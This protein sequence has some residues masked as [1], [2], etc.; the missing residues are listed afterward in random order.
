MYIGC[1]GGVYGSANLG[2]TFFELNR[3]Y[4][5]QTFY[6]IANSSALNKV[7]GGAQDNGTIYIPGDGSLPTLQSG[8]PASGG[9]G[10]G[11]E[12]SLVTEGATVAF[13]TSQNNSL[14][15]INVSAAA[16]PSPFYD[17]NITNFTG[18]SDG[19]GLPF[20]TDI[21][22]FE[23]TEDEDSQQTIELVNPYDYDLFDADLTDDTP[24]QLLV[25]TN[26]K[27]I[28]F[29]YTLEDT[30]HY[31]ATIER[32]EL[33]TL[34]PLTQDPN[35]WWLNPQPFDTIY[36]VCVVDT[37]EII[38]DTIIGSINPIE[39]CDTTYFTDTIF[40]QG[41]SIP[42]DT[43]FINC[44]TLG[45]DTI[46]VP[47][48]T[49]ITETICHD[50]Y[51]Y[52]A[53]VV[54]NV[55]EHKLI[56][57]PYTSLFAL[58]FAGDDGIWVT[59]E[60]LNFNVSPSWMRIVDN[61]PGSGTKALTFSTDGDRLYYTGWGTSSVK[62][63]SNL[64]Q[65]YKAGDNGYTGGDIDN[66]EISTVLP[67]AGGQITGIACDYHN[68]NHMVV[69][70]GQYGQVSNGK[71]QETWNALDAN[72][73]WSNI[74]IPNNSPDPNLA[75]MPCYDVI[76]DREDETGATII[77]GTE[78][79]IFATENG[80]DSW[81]TEVND[82]ADPSTSTGI[83]RTPVFDLRQQV[84][85]GK[86]WWH[87]ENTGS[88]Y[89]GTHGR[90][91]FRSDATLDPAVGIDE[92]SASK[93]S[94][95]LSIYPNPTNA[96][97]TIEFT[98]SQNQDVIINVFSIQGELVKTITKDNLTKGDKTLKLDVKDLPIGNYILQLDAGNS[99]KVGKFVIMR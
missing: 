73:S 68:P 9:D 94:N 57:D 1:D 66:L 79:G 96:L 50:E 33:T 72:P 63:V 51:H 53:D 40:F 17:N 81:A 26:N 41:D 38:I 75:K 43:F 11:C 70:V 12:I 98:L 27:N 88:I 97:A 20:H 21:A 45:Y 71:V 87:P 77:V 7:L 18:L 90:G 14:G 4:N 59:R 82:P 54:E 58:G 84:V 44:I 37:T 32:P 36:N 62:V 80:G 86:R 48:T 23:D 49:F 61:A 15:R 46:F 83:D 30:L 5:T 8:L 69:S 67:S 13:V 6:K 10:F 60:A 95:V 16:P 65:L 19:N 47:D 2:Q 91:I 92:A 24:V 52:F 89:A 78:F 34:E 55:R 35:Y 56:Q 74:W 25:H 93:D 22:L 31:W 39:F 42:V 64:D 99:S 85:L 29:M 28:P 3:G 76:I